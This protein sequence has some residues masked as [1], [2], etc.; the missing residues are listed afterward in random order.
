MK[1]VISDSTGGP[2]TLRYGQLPMP[3][4]GDG[5]LLIRVHACGLNYPDLLMVEGKYQVDPPRP[6]VPGI[7]VAGEV[8]KIGKGAN[9]FAAGDRVSAMMDFGGMAEYATAR[10]EKCVALPP[11]IPFDDAAAFVTTHG[12]SYHA[13]KQRARLAEGDT[14]LVLGAAGGVGLAAVELGKLMGARVIAAASSQ[15][16]VDL[17]LQRGADIGLAYPAGMSVEDIKTLSQRFKKVAGTSGIDVVYDPV[18]GL[19]AEAA[20]RAIAWRGRFLVVGFPAG[21][22]SIPLNLP[23]LKGAEI[24]G[25]FYGSF[26][27]R[28]PQRYMENLRELMAYYLAG[29]FRPCISARYSFADASKAFLLLSRRE[30]TGKIV[31]TPD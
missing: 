26:V 14:L 17:A 1:A 15:Q 21:I 4:A 27:E 16:K 10:A 13:L 12:T 3:E 20:F 23:L 22:P 6:F 11:G 31:L 30:A 19:Y 2:E 28:E 9:G 18:G 29:R 5:Q 24:V 7:E 8:V 25:V